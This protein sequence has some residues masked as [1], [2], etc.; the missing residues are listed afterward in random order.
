MKTIANLLTSLIIAFW[1]IAIAVLSVQNAEPISLKFLSFQSI[2]IPFGLV[3]AF[4]AGIGI[5]SVAI[6]KPLWSIA[7]LETGSSKLDDEPEFFSD[8]DF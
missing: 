3:L 8:E 4:S 6:L 1:V 7:G 2:Q 5:M